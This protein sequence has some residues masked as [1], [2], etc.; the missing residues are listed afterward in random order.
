MHIIGNNDVILARKSIAEYRQLTNNQ[1]NAWSW[2]ALYVQV[3]I[4]GNG[5]VFATMSVVKPVEYIKLD[6]VID[7]PSDSGK[8]E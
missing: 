2:S 1:R 5:K 8:V 6:F 3:S 7:N 4:D